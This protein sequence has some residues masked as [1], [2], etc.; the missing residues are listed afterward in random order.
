MGGKKP[1]N[2]LLLLFCLVM[3]GSYG[4][5]DSECCES[6]L[7]DSLAEDHRVVGNRLG[8][9]QQFGQYGARPAYK[10]AGGDYFIFF[11]EDQDVW[12]ETKYF[13]GASLFS[14]LENDNTN[15]C[16]ESYN[17]WSRYN[18]TDMVFA[19]KMQASCQ[20][21]ENLCCSTIKLSSINVNL[22]DSENQ[23]L[24]QSNA[25]AALGEYTAIGMKGGRWV[26]QKMWEDRYLEYGDRYWLG[27]TGVGKTSGHIHHNGGS[28]CPESITGEWQISTKSSEG[29]WSW[30]TDLGLLVTCITETPETPET[31]ETQKT[32]K[33]QKK[34]GI[35]HHPPSRLSQEFRHLEFKETPGYYQSAVAFGVM[36]MILAILL[37]LF[38]ARRFRT[39]WGRGAQGKKLLIE[40]LEL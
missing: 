33:T 37:I 40:T 3:N 30:K 12:T 6:I 1:K 19:E 34:N 17:N 23:T 21:I 29:D 18:G 27:S 32:Q 10:Q 39:A 9:Y 35:T 13:F 25:R 26:Y 14:R 2:N 31:P 4:K 11:D 16:L 15:Y 36:A 8:F 5:K 38:L 24:Y 7:F 28:I 22:T 20:S